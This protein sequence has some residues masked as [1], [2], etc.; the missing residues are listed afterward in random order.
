[1]YNSWGAKL[2]GGKCSICGAYYDKCEHID[3]LIYFGRLC[4]I[5]GFESLEADHSSLVDNPRD[6]RCIINKIS[7]DEG[8]MRDY[9]TWKITDE[10]VS[11]AEGATQGEGRYLRC[12]LFVNKTIEWD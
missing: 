6:R 2:K 4:T 5:I 9:I 7:T 3:G 10:P 8:F 1:M 12:T 11:Q